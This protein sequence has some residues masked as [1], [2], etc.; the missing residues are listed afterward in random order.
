MYEIT[1]LNSNGEKFSKTFDS[2][3]LYNKYLQKVKHS[4]KVTVL[5]YGKI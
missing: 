4:K 5:S 2:Y 3:Y 1:M